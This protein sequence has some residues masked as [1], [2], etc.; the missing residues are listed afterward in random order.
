MTERYADACPQSNHVH[1]TGTAIVGAKLHVD[2][3]RVLRLRDLV[4]DLCGWTFRDLVL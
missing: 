4:S 1:Y 3:I 2:C